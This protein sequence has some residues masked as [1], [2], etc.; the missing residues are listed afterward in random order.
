VEWL[1]TWLLGRTFMEHAPGGQFEEVN[2]VD[3]MIKSNAERQLLRLK[4]GA[5]T[6]S[7]AIDFVIKNWIPA[8]NLRAATDDK[9]RQKPI[10]GALNERGLR[11]LVEII[12]ETKPFI[13]EVLKA[14]TVHLERRKDGNVALHC[15]VGKD[16]AGVLAMLCVSMLGVAD[17]DIIDDFTKSGCIRSLAEKRYIEI[18]KGQADPVR[19]A[20]A[21]PETMVHTLEYLRGK[22]GSIEK[23]LDSADF[24]ET[25]RARFCRV[26]S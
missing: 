21:S 19:F 9:E 20:D 16:R 26:A 12:L 3:S 25:W 18:F 5:L 11:G 8:E 7:G 22:Y 14:M 23:Y 15:N 2:S 24:D 4:D 17:Q 10:F 1:E 13:S 6:R